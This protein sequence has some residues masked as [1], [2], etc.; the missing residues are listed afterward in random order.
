ML[1]ARRANNIEGDNM[2]IIESIRG[3]FFIDEITLGDMHF[4]DIMKCVC[5]KNIRIMRY[6]ELEQAIEDL[7]LILRGKGLNR[8]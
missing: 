1:S 7:D 3:Q 5:N 8:W 4:Y 2:K 6:R